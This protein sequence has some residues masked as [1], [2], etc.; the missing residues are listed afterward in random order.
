MSGDDVLAT[1][2]NAKTARDFTFGGLGFE[3]GQFTGILIN[4]KDGDAIM[5]AI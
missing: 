5:A 3:K 2:I 1:R 4:G